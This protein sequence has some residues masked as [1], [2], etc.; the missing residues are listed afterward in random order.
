MLAKLPLF[1]HH[2]HSKIAAIAY[3]LTSQTYSSGKIIVR[4]NDPINYVLLIA[5]G[6]VKVYA[7][8]EKELENENSGKNNNNGPTIGTKFSTAPAHD[9]SNVLSKRIPRL[10]VS[11]LGKGYLIG[12]TEFYQNKK[13]FQ[14][15]YETNSINTEILF[16]PINVF[17]ESILVGDFRNSFAFKT[18]EMISDEREDRIKKNIVKSREIMHKKMKGE[19]D[20]INDRENLIKILPSIIDSSLPTAPNRLYSLDSSI[21]AVKHQTIQALTNNNTNIDPEYGIKVTRKATY[22][23]N[24]SEYLDS[25]KPNPPNKTLKKSVNFQS[26]RKSIFSK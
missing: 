17:K 16:M 9:V 23:V 6:E 1:K 13:T 2:I 10:A 14:M 25:N 22:S 4:Y 11:L 21:A 5:S 15:T 24:P 26:P 3:T 8:T 12:E 20:K 7:P 19:T 18:I